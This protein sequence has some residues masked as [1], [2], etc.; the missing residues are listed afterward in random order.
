MNRDHFGSAGNLG[1]ISRIVENH[2]RIEQILLIRSKIVLTVLQI[3]DSGLNEVDIFILPEHIFVKTLFGAVVAG[4]Q[5]KAGGSGLNKS[6]GNIPE[7]LAHK[8]AGRHLF[9]I[10]AA[11]EG[12]IGNIFRDL[13]GRF[14]EPLQCGGGSSIADKTRYPL[15]RKFFY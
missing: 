5:S 9:D 7:H 2:K 1:R 14:F 12:N 10:A 4:F 13:F 3:G 8:N 15:A 11:A 6:L